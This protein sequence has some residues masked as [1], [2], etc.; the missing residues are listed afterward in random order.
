MVDAIC[1]RIGIAGRE[2]FLKRAA[3]RVAIAGMDARIKAL[4]GRERA[5]IVGTSQRGGRAVPAQRTG[6]RVELPCRDGGK[7]ER[8]FEHMLRF[9][10]PD[11]SEE[12]TSELPSL[13]RLSYDVFCLKHN[14]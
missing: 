11:R 9:V 4:A 1:H 6:A 7:V 12:H 14:N 8:A 3:H 13:M 5:F 10:A 2:R